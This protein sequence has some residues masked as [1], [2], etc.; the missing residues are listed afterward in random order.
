MH[1]L[2][3]LFVGLEHFV[4]FG[5]GGEVG[6]LVD[7]GVLILAGPLQDFDQLAS[8]LWSSVIKKTRLRSAPML[9]SMRA[10]SGE[11]A[12]REDLIGLSL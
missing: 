1:R 5:I 11:R 2:E 10:D 8:G 6:G 3:L 12:V 4:V 9:V 7:E